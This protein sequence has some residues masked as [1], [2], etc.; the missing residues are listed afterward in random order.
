MG[1]LF[2]KLD[3]MPLASAPLVAGSRGT[4]SS[5]LISSISSSNSMMTAL[6]SQAS[7][8]TGVSAP[9]PSFSPKSLISLTG[10]G[11]SESTKPRHKIPELKGLSAAPSSAPRKKQNPKKEAKV[12]KEIKTYQLPQKVAYLNISG[13]YDKKNLANPIMDTTEELDDDDDMIGEIDKKMRQQ[14]LDRESGDSVTSVSQHLLSINTNNSDG[15]IATH[16][17][18]ND[19]NELVSDH[20]ISS[21]HKYIQITFN[22]AKNQQELHY[23]KEQLENI[24]HKTELQG[25]LCTRDWPNYPL[26]SLSSKSIYI[27]IYIILYIYIYI[28][29]N[30]DKF[31]TK[32]AI[33]APESLT[34]ISQEKKI[35]QSI[36]FLKSKAQFE[37]L[38][39]R[40]NSGTNQKCK[41]PNS[42]GCCIY[43][44]YS[45]Y[46]R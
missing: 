22:K 39:S 26:P 9:L 44:F 13:I 24:I 18:V 21:L 12:H 41:S 40:Y 31:G 6:S 3:S 32:L 23:L 2:Q 45:C 16:N 4:L 29:D 5:S 10:R 25:D 27:Y 34:N 17:L 33:I 42:L 30:I 14:L 11:T 8:Q 35:P 7:K 46:C 1:G 19:T 36:A 38:S 28:I 15:N 37:K 43:I 20:G